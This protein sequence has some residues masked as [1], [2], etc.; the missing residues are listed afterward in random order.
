M[1]Y[2]KIKRN[3]KYI[4]MKDLII[5]GAGPA[6]CSAGIYAAR[7]KM[8]TLL[9]ARDF[10]GQIA[11]THRV[12]NYPGIKE[13]SGL[14]LVKQFEDHLRSTD[15][16]IKPFEEVLGIKGDK[17]RF[18][19]DTDGGQYESRAVI[20]ATG[21][22]PKKLGVENE[23]RFLNKGISYCV[24]CD[25]VSFEDKDVAVI[26]GGNAG[27]EAVLQLSRFVKKV[28]LFECRDNLTADGILIDRMGERDNVDIITSSTIKSFEG[29]DRL[30]KIVYEVN[31]RDEEVLVDGCF[32]EIGSVPNTGF[33]EGFV[34][35]NKK[36]EVV[37]NP[38]TFQTSQ[39]GIF[40]AGDIVDFKDKQVVIAT[41]QGAV[42][43]LS[44]F[45]YLEC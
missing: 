37:V 5:I 22:T 2:G 16:E 44:V 11:L 45:R 26:G 7:K 21:S 31:G 12:E 24:T 10:T 23:E 9:I 35:L 40:A 42:A 36:G 30:E 19:V 27:L 32:V 17:D 43:A 34:E 41:G 13:I 33:L 25:G 3:F 39:E 29:E 28:Y 4:D 6:G 8:D 20:V 18:L 14:N 1:G 38:A 15:I